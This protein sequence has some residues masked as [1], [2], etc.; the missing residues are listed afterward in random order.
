MRNVHRVGPERQQ[1]RRKQMGRPVNKRY[2]G[3]GSGN[4][5]KVRAKIGSNAEGDG[6][7]VSQRGTNRFNVTVGSDTGV[8][9]LVNKNTG[10]LGDNEMIINVATDAGVWRQATKLFNRVAIIEGNEKVAWNFDSSQ[11]DDAVQVADVEGSNTLTITISSQPANATANVTANANV[12]V[13]FSVTATGVGDLAYQW[14]K[15]ESGA[16]A[17]ASVNGATAS[18]LTLGSLSI[19]NDNT[20]RYRVVVS[21]QS[22]AASPVTSNSAVL[23]VV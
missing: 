18:S 4:Q 19:V 11:S 23:S 21:S 8:C 9:T 10:S 1:T 5:I 22:G 6:V 2:F 17:W 20:D 16:G 13:S 7:I 15:Q 12:T 14:Q 3:S